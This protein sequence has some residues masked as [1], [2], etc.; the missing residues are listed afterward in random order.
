[1]ADYDIESMQAEDIVIRYFN[2]LVRVYPGP[3]GLDR[4]VIQI[5]DNDDN[6][7][8]RAEDIGGD[9]MVIIPEL[10]NVAMNTHLEPS[11]FTFVT[12]MVPH[13][14]FLSIQIIVKPNQ[15]LPFFSPRDSEGDEEDDAD[16]HGDDDDGDDSDGDLENGIFMD[17]RVEI[18][19]QL[20]ID[21]NDPDLQDVQIEQGMFRQA[22]DDDDGQE[23]DDLEGFDGAAFDQVA[24]D[25]N[26]HD[27]SFELDE[28]DEEE[29]DRD[30]RSDSESFYN[31]I[32]TIYQRMMFYDQIERAELL[33]YRFLQNE[34]QREIIRLNHDRLETAFNNVADLIEEWVD[35]CAV[36]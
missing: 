31:R 17:V 10:I 20:G 32:M 16:D 7:R 21:P 33:L 1:M 22:S 2:A 6:L 9:Y 26:T 28:A 27:V 12:L 34:R 11:E 8:V 18:L 30:I 24:F 15:P 4:H 36:G 25:Q 3:A 14:R 23:D 35:F 19:K 13:S 5:F 29:L